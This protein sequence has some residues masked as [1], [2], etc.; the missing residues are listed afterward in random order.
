[1]ILDLA[2]LYQYFGVTGIASIIMWIAGLLVFVLFA[3]SRKRTQR[4]WLALGVVALGLVLARINSMNVS[5]IRV[6]QTAEIEAGRERG[7]RLSD[8]D[9][10]LEVTS[11][12]STTNILEKAADTNEQ[13]YSYRDRGKVER[14]EGKTIGKKVAGVDARKEIVVEGRMMKSHDVHRAN[15]L[16]KIN[17]FCARAALWLAL[18]IV[19]LDY[20]RRLNKTFDCYCPLP[21]ASPLLDSLYPKTLS[22]HV[23]PGKKE[24]MRPFLENAVRKGETFIYFGN[25]DLWQEPGLPRLVVRD[26]RLWPLKKV[27]CSLGK[28]PLDGDSVFESA[29]F[30]RYCFVVEGEEL[31]KE[32][33][34]ALETFLL[35]RHAVRARAR[36]TVNIVWDL[37]TDIDP[38]R[39]DELLFLCSDTNHKLVVVGKAVSEDQAASRFQELFV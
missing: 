17:L 39:L 36:R 27:T 13:A 7:R 15:A 24:R 31:S 22:V 32:W 4:Y 19:L 11:D 33:L 12:I 38:D 8:A 34:S 21:L 5:A 18:F 29:W 6:D 37:D 30:G 9:A 2:K 16:D 26:R 20:L 1:M 28:S 25:A 23:G 3:W 10:G 14:D 35:A